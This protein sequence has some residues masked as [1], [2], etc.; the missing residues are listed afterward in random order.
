MASKDAWLER[1]E[2]FVG[3]IENDPGMSPRQAIEVLEE[4]KRLI[5]L[6]IET[7]EA[8]L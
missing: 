7:K 4:L 5:D 2:D 8:E 3:E 1:V 6:T